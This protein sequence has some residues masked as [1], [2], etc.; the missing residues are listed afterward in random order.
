MATR[1]MGILHQKRAP[2]HQGYSSLSLNCD[3]FSSSGS[4]FPQAERMA[5]SS[6]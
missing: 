2:I 1:R 4:Q 6:P 3:T 5:W